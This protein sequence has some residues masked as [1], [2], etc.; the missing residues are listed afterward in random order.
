MFFIPESLKL[1]IEKLV[2]SRDSGSTSKPKLIAVG[3]TTVRALESAALA[4]DFEGCES[5]VGFDLS[6][7]SGAFRGTRLCIS[8]GFNFQLV[9]SLVTN[10][11]L[12]NS[13]HLMLVNAFSGSELTEKIY[14][15]A[16]KQDYGFFS[17]GDG[18][19]LL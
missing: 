5:R 15:H 18:M 17:Y 3:T 12:P 16:L 11:H 6:S 14:S 13:S 1:K 19:L 8:P 2:R 10:F 9:D 7:Y 4:G